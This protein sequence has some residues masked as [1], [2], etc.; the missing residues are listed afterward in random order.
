MA[1]EAVSLDAAEPMANALLGYSNAYIGQYDA[2]LAAAKR[3]IELNPSFAVG[4]HA[5]GMVRMFNGEPAKAIDAIERAVRISPEDLWLPIWLGTLSAS[6]YLMYDYE[7]ALQVAR[8]SVQRAPHYPIGQRSL[9]NALAQLGRMEE[10]REA[11]AAFLA[12]SPNYNDETARRSAVFRRESDYEHYV[13]G[14][15]KAGWEG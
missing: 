13:E 2:G 8:L 11:L 12:L 6:C 7:K 3:A 14:L 1:L 15:R 4:H 9:A 5:L 10:A